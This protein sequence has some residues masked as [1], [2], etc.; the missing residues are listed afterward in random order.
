VVVVPSIGYNI[1]LITRCVASTSCI[2]YIRRALLSIHV[3]CYIQVCSCFLHDCLI[4]GNIREM[5]V[6]WSAS[7]QGN[8]KNGPETNLF[9]NKEWGNL[10][11]PHP[12]R[13]MR[14]YPTARLKLLTS[15]ISRRGGEYLKLLT[16]FI[17]RR[18][19]YSPPL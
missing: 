2:F 14:S 4:E 6:C 13:M 1:K 3:H 9:K 17:S 15:F 18:A 8:G 11:N 7:V 10:P 19:R 16:S 12:S 5:Q